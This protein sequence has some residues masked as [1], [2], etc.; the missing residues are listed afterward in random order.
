MKVIYKEVIVYDNRVLTQV[1]KVIHEAQCEDK[2]I[3]YISLSK[4][5]MEQFREAVIRRHGKCHKDI[6]G[7]VR[8][9]RVL[10]KT[11]DSVQETATLESY[12]IDYYPWM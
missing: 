6:S 8:Y 2:D 11:D 4:E 10:I 12:E 1:D 5:D 9:R 3:L 7:S